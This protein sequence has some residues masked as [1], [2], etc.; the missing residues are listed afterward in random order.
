MHLLAYSK[1]TSRHQPAIDIVPTVAWQS[2]LLSYNL[3]SATT[4]L[5]KGFTQGFM[6]AGV[7][8]G[9]L[10]EG[11]T[12]GGG[13]G[14]S[15]SYELRSLTKSKS[16]TKSS[17]LNL[18]TSEPCDTLVQGNAKKQSMLTIAPKDSS[19]CRK[20]SASI[21]SHDSRRIMIRREWEI[22]ED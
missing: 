17:Q 10:R 21:T 15:G 7:S 19:K 3:I 8:L 5:L 16:K 6:T 14:L 20:E 9:Y 13:S 18:T 22:S 12:T 1:F 2:V 11:G 4:P